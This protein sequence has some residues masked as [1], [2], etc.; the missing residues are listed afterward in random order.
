MC[1]RLTG[2]STPLTF[3][4][5]ASGTLNPGSRIDVYRFTGSAGQRLYYDALQRDPDNTGVSLMSPNGNFLFQMDSD[6]ERLVTLTESGTYYLFAGES[7][8]A[9][10][11]YSFRL[12]DMAAQPAPAIGSVVT[13]TLDPGLQANV[14]RLN[15]AAGQR[16]YFDDRPS[17]FNGSDGTS[18]WNL[19]GPDNGN[20]TSG[21]ILNHPDNTDSEY[22]APAAGEYLLV[23]GGGDTAA[24]VNYSMGILD[25]DATST[26]LNLGNATTGV[27]DPGSATAIYR[28]TGAAGQRLVL[29]A[30]QNDPDSVNLR[31][32]AP[33]GA[34]LFEIN[35]DS[36]RGVFTLGESGTYYVVLRGRQ[37][38]TADFSFRLFDV[39]AQPQVTV[40]ATVADTLN[41]GLSA[42][43]YRFTGTAGQWLTFDARPNVFD[44]NDP[45]SRWT[46]FD[47]ADRQVNSALMVNHPDN[48]DFEVTLGSTGEYVLTVAGGAGAPVPFAFR[49][50][51][52]AASSVPLTLGTP[53]TGTLNPGSSVAVYQFSGA[54]GQRLYFDA[55]QRDPDSVFVRL[56]GPDGG[57][58]YSDADSDSDRGPVTLPENGT[59]HLVFRGRMNTPA[60][61]GFTLS[62]LA[63]A[64]AI[65]F[66]TD[67]SGNLNPGLRS[68]VYRFNG[69]AG[70]RLYFDNRSAMNTFDGSTRWLL[71]GPDDRNIGSGSLVY[72]YGSTDFELTLPAT[73]TYA[74]VVDGE[75]AAAEVNYAFRVIDVG[76][77]PQVLTLG[78]TTQGTLSPGT[79]T[80]VYKFTVAAG[81][82]VV[83]DGLQRDSDAVSVR[84]LTPGSVQVFSID[85]DSDS[86]P[87]TLTEPGTYTLILYG[88]EQAASADYAFR[89]LDVAAAPL[90]AFDTP[91][92]GSL[93]PGI[94][95]AVYRFHASRGQHVLFES[96]SGDAGGT[97]NVYRV[98]DRNVTGRNLTDSFDAVLN[99][100]GEYVIVLYGNNRNAAVNYAFRLTLL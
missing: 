31:I 60:D 81:R 51:D 27:I 92:T 88:N 10:A 48:T 8:N 100:D 84:L 40:G 87:V 17:V 35:S 89:L 85:A 67:V 94:G 29:D 18:R 54:A 2:N 93:N 73:G 26:P 83:Y 33:N 38:A 11:D 28:F 15:L 36:D 61:Y 24:P 66:D 20:R 7:S 34:G 3:G 96:L 55:L 4:A 53:T 45:S 90:V 91:V 37:A 70:Q 1:R 74:I 99:G 22:Q 12:L 25:Y 39:A 86:S 23:F 75:N 46:L 6:S 13:G 21:Y 42:N 95:N 50:L 16:L 64:P 65:A 14:Y 63:A 76:A 72:Q 78:A 57:N 98:D 77:T 69:V 80:A 9:T 32:N 62:D 97:W 49:I 58:V 52:M 43:V 59:Y 30:L 19:Y 44:G 68:A 41:P 56:V 79:A 47:P 82:R 5:A 71:H